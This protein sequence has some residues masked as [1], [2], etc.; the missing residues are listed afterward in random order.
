MGSAVGIVLIQR[1]GIHP[2][3]PAILIGKD[4]KNLSPVAP[5]QSGKMIDPN[6]PIRRRH[7]R[8]G[9]AVRQCVSKC[10]QNKLSSPSWGQAACP[11]AAMVVA[12]CSFSPSF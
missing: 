2:G 9:A 12:F 1:S 11:D 6:A 5:E 4:R 10:R 3:D 7:G 8:I